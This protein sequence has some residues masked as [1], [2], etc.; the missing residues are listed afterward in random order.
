MSSEGKADLRLEIAHVLFMDVVGYSKLLVDE[1]TETLELLNRIVRGTGEFRTAEQKGELMRLPTGDGMAL[2]FLTNPEDPVQCALEISKAIKPHPELQLRMGI[3]SGPVN[4]M[5]DVNDRSNVTGAG[6]NM[7]QRVMDCGD[8]GHIL[9]SKRAADDLAQYRH[10]QPLLHD[11]GECEVKHGVNVHIVNLYTDE[12]GNAARPAKLTSK[13]PPLPAPTSSAPSGRRSNYGLITASLIALALVAT[14][15]WFLSGKHATAPNSASPPPL[16]APVPEKSIAVLPFENLSSDKENAYFADGIQDEILTKLASIADLKVISRT[17]TAKYKSKPEDLKT[18]SQQLAVATVLEGTVQK[19]GDKVR[20]NVQLIDARADTHLWAKSYDR[21]LK[22]VFAVESE[23]SQEV[24]DALRAKLSPSEANVL[25]AAPTRDPEAYDLFLKG[26]YEL[27]QGYSLRLSEWYDRADAHYRQALSRDPNFALAAAR[28]AYSRLARHWWLTLLTSGELDEVKTVLDR[29]LALAPDLGESHQALGM[30]YY[31]GHRDYEP[32]LKEFRRALE[33]QPNNARVR[34]Y[35]GAVYRRQGQWERSLAEMTKAEELDPRDAEIPAEIALTYVNLRQWNEA[36]RASSR[37]LALDPHTIVGMSGLVL[38]YVNEDGDPEAAERALAGLPAGARLKL[39]ATRGSISNVIDERTYLHV[40]RRDFAAALKDWEKESVDPT[41]RMARLSARVAIR[42]LAGDTVNA[43]ADSEEARVLLE[44]RLRERPDDGFAMTQLS[45]V[46]VA[47]DRNADALRLA[48]QAA[49]SL[50]IERDAFSG[51]LFAVG[52]AQIQA[53]TG[54]PREAVKTLRYL[55]SIPAGW[56]LSL[57]RLKI[58]PVWD[59]I[60][61]D[62]EFQ[63]LLAGN[64]QI[65]PNK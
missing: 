44:A 31:W 57:K 16:T 4:R 37:S 43:K 51:P 27:R 48:H 29:A 50:P 1:Q 54:Q 7:A 6:I 26:E 21:D 13:Q 14:F 47:L 59:P 62:M 9:L 33:V 23:V 55:L 19:A 24:A 12:V 42:V 65:G 25:A 11:V 20:V 41:E 56:P 53:R 17:S 45:W 28:L 22:D 32:A 34:F 52:L 10:W 61:N 8:A 49:E 39:N 2:V 36:K 35:S 5:S 58:D 63:Q 64:E 60:R 15:V 30:F 46:Y 38:S 3:H 40:F 18:V